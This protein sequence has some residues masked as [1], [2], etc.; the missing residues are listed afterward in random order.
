MNC[1][2]GWDVEQQE[3]E[4]SYIGGAKRK[5]T[6]STVFVSDGMN[7]PPESELTPQPGA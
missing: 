6:S 5:A 1:R 2:A 4:K 7:P 3:G